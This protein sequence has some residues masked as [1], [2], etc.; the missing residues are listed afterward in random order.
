MRTLIKT[1]AASAT[2]AAVG[3]IGTTSD[4][5]WYRSLVKPRWQPPSIAFPLVWTPLYALIAIG[6]ARMLDAEPDPGTRKRLRAL[7]AAN[8]AVNAGWCWAFFSAESPPAGL[9]T[10]VALDGL[11]VALLNEARKR[12]TTAALLLSPYAAWTL[13]ATALNAEIVR[14]N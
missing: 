4:S 3:S 12:D 9:V 1:L 10:I 11:N 5:P 6:T 8:L 7:V 2:A 14:L 13:F